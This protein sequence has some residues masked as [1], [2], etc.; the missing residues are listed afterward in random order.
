MSRPNLIK[1]VGYGNLL[2]EYHKDCISSF[3]VSRSTPWLSSPVFRAMFVPSYDIK[4]SQVGNGVESSDFQ[5]I[6][7]GNNDVSS[8][9]IAFHFAEPPSIIEYRF[10]RSAQADLVCDRYDLKQALGFGLTLGLNKERFL[11]RSQ[12]ISY[13]PQRRLL[14]IK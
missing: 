9:E 5:R 3:L 4:E 1:T 11:P 6:L 2:I 12:G 10:S 13:F 8:M 7:F 14:K